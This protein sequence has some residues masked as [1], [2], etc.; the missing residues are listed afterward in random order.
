[1]VNAKCAPPLGKFRH[2]FPQSCMVSTAAPTLLDTVRDAVRS[3]HYSLRTERAYLLWIR[4]FVRF[5]GLRHPRDLG[6]PEVTAFL[7]AL[8]NESHV[9]A[10]TQN[11]ALAAVLFLY[12]VV[13]EQEL[14]WLD[15]VVRAKKPRRLPTVLTQ[16]EAR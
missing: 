16:S 1:M 13:L 5:H 6:G 8:A 3:R 9:A 4:R 15:E 12:R 7:S 11:Q 10:A 14:P 2:L